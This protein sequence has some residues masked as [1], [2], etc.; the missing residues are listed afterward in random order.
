MDTNINVFELLKQFLS[1]TDFSDE[2]K[3]K[4]EGLLN[5][6]NFKNMTSED[7]DE[8]MKGLD[9]ARDK[10]EEETLSSYDADEINKL[11]DMKEFLNQ[12]NNEVEENALKPVLEM[13]GQ[14]EEST[15]QSGNSSLDVL[16]RF[17]GLS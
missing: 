11:T 1:Y 14:A 9:A 3:S 10:M 15:E 16:N 17:V 13:G 4:F 12:I 8:L 6:E 2:Q 7:A 5:P